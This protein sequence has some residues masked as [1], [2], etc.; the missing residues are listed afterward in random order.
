MTQRF[1]INPFYGRLD[2]AD[3]DIGPAGDVEF[4]EGDA[5]GSV[6][7]NAGKVVFLLGGVGCSVTGVPGTNTLTINVSGGGLDWTVQSST[8]KTIES[9]FGYI[10]DTAGLLTFVLP[11]TSAVGDV[12]EVVGQGAGGWTITQGAGQSIR[13]GNLSS[14]VGAGGSVASTNRYDTIQCTCVVANLTWQVTKAVGVLNI[15]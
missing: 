14:T 9:H 6:P 4:I 5:G 3:E 10:T 12:F 7:P 13:E 1:K 8:P 11:A 15:T 2:I